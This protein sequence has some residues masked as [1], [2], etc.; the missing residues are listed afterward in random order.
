MARYTLF[1]AFVACLCLS[2]TTQ[3]QT[4]VPKSN[5]S[6]AILP[7]QSEDLIGGFDEPAVRASLAKAMA[8]HTDRVVPASQ[9]AA[10]VPTPAEVNLNPTVEEAAT[11][12]AKLGCDFYITARVVR[13]EESGPDRRP[14]FVARI[15]FFVVDS[16]SGDLLPSTPV[17]ILAQTPEDLRQT[18]TGAVWPVSKAMYDNCERRREEDIRDA[19]RESSDQS[20]EIVDLRS[21]DIPPEITLPGIFQR[22]KPE[23]TQTAR[24]ARIETTLTA[25]IVFLPNGKIGEVSIVRWGGYGL[26]QA[27]RNAVGSYRFKPARKNGAPV[28]VRLLAE[29]KFRTVRADP[30]TQE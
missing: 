18:E 7:F 1:L 13:A 14:R 9:V 24:D 4:D 21:G 3:A 17:F 16:R 15:F 29:F 25:D 19:A 27:V 6:V 26:E 23:V 12:G 30:V 20:G 22:P 2:L 8:R 5:L 11:V 10:I 28:G